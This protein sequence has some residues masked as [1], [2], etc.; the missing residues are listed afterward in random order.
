MELRADE[1]RRA[2]VQKPWVGELLRSGIDEGDAEE[3][4]DR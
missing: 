3:Q 4:A 1:G 2:W